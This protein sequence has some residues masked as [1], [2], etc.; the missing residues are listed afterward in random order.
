[1]FSFLIGTMVGGSLGVVVMCVF[2]INR[3]ER[4]D[5]VL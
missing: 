4:K 1:M 5:D 3:D 2:Q